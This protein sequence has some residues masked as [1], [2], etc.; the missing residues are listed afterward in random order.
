MFADSVL[1]DIKNKEKI[2]KII[3]EESHKETFENADE[4]IQG[5][6]PLE[7]YDLVK[8]FMVNKF[9]EAIR[10]LKDVN[11]DFLSNFIAAIA[12]RPGVI[13]L[14]TTYFK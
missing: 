5:F 2:W 7:Q 13:K 6:S 1:P 14:V 11:M 12:P 3:V 8:D 9:F 10:Q 4:L